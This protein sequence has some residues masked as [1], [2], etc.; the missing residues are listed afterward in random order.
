MTGA[1]GGEGGSGSGLLAGDAV[2]LAD[3]GNSRIKLARLVESPARGGA[4]L[5]AIDRRQDLDSHTFR[6]ENL[7]RW[8]GTV[9][10]GP[11][12]ILVASVHDTAAARL[13]A[14]VAEI[15]ATRHRPIRQRRI[16]HVDLPLE[17]RLPEPHR[18]GI[19]RLAGAAACRLVAPAGRACVLVDCGTAATVDLIAADG[20]FLGGAILPGPVLMARALADGASRLTAAAVSG[21][22]APPPMPGRSTGEAIAVG[23]GF[24]MQGAIARL[25][26]EARCVLGPDAVTVLT[27]GW[28]AAVREALP[29]AIEVPDLVLA[30]IALAVS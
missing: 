17:V 16:S 23:I 10:P 8:L 13:E 20:S 14:A 5:P 25:E 19:D 22:A 21:P 15:S 7:E 26:A 4:G 29:E 3:V 6:P 28:R 1:V 27:G 30:G 18:V 24:G 12:V 9:A 11:A 2:L